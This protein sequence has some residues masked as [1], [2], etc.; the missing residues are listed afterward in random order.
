MTPNVLKI[1]QTAN[2]STQFYGIHLPMG[3]VYTVL[4]A[5]VHNGE[6]QPK[7]YAWVENP[8]Q[9]YNHRHFV[10]RLLTVND[11]YPRS[12]YVDGN[13][14]FAHSLRAFIRALDRDSLSINRGATSREI[15]AIGAPK[16]RQ[17]GRYIQ[18]GVPSFETSPKVMTENSVT[19]GVRVGPVWLTQEGYCAQRMGMSV[20]NFSKGKS[21]EKGIISHTD[22]AYDE[23]INSRKHMRNPEGNPEGNPEDSLESLSLDVPF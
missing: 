9:A 5:R 16:D 2:H 1:R 19:A 10:V 11:K 15:R 6:F 7:A 17:V 8:V 18:R 14:G 3:A 13:Y 21:M 20:P 23:W 22:K 4:P 12:V